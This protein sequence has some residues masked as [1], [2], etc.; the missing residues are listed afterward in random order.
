MFG[1][2]KNKTPPKPDLVEKAIELQKELY[3]LLRAGLKCQDNEINRLEVTYLSATIYTMA[4]LIFGKDQNAPATL[5]KFTSDLFK[6]VLP[7]SRVNVTFEEAV[8]TYQTRYKEH[9]SLLGL[10]LD[11]KK[12]QTGSPET[13]ALMHFYEK[14]TNSTAHGQMLQIQLMSPI[15]ADLFTESLAD[16]KNFK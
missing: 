13:T 2:F 11:P 6:K 9:S 8:A 10:I 12:S 5:D 15:L 7:S 4:Y 3:D 14:A 1:F 16:I